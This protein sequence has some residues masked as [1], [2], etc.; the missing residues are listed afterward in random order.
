MGA[1]KTQIPLN[2]RLVQQQIRLILSP[3]N[4]IHKGYSPGIQTQG[5][6]QGMERLPLPD[7]S[8]GDD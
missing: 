5:L 2:F 3:S 1:D 7:I 6:Q 4:G 8:F